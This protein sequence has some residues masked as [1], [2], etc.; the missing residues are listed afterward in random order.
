MLEL[1]RSLIAELGLVRA[2]FGR[3]LAFRRPL[4]AHVSFRGMAICACRSR[5]RPFALPGYS[6]IPKSGSRFSEKIMFQ[7]RT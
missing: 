2:R 5:R 7:G 1:E 4:T 3:D 6:M